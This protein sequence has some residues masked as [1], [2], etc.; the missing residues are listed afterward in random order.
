M[1]KEFTEQIFFGQ[2]QY[3]WISSYTE[4]CA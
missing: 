2:W 4:P 1:K 3:F